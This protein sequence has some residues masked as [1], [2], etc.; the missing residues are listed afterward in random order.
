[1]LVNNPKLV[2]KHDQAH[3]KANHLIQRALIDSC[4]KF[5]DFT[6]EVND[7][8]RRE[9]KQKKLIY[10]KENLQRF[11]DYVDGIGHQMNLTGGEGMNDLLQ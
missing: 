9:S 5:S 7:E 8:I 11:V 3:S 2:T 1:M 6:E 10:D 4:H